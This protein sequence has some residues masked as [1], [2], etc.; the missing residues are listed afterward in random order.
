MKEHPILFTGEMVRAI[1]D[2]RKTQT[3]RVMKAQ[4]AEDDLPLHGPYWY[5]LGV[6]D[7]YGEMHPGPKVYGISSADGEFGLKCPY[8]APGDR[9]WV[10]ETWRNSCDDTGTC[11]V[12]WRA[13]MKACHSLADHDGHGDLCGF[14]PGYIDPGEQANTRWRPSIHMPRWASR[15][16]LE[17]TNIRVEMVQEISPIDA[18]AEG[19]MH[20]E[21]DYASMTAKSVFGDLW[22]S[23]NAKRGYGWSVN[24]WVWV[25]GFKKL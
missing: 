5:T 13:D 6:Y 23:I 2:G 16:T 1:L 12:Q 10:R 3:R 25:V 22:D 19:A 24:P 4:P 18:V 7:K 11:I 15:I 14:K 20:P 21:A 17:V 8:G 9:L